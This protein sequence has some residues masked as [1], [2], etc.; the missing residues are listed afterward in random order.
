MSTFDGKRRLNLRP[1][2]HSR[3]GAWIREGRTWD[4]E[5]SPSNR[6]RGKAKRD[7]QRHRYGR[8]DSLRDSSGA[9]SLNFDIHEWRNEIFEQERLKRAS[10]QE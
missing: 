10:N 7:W 1:L 6:D 4:E 8:E 5:F 9:Y 2:R 3:M